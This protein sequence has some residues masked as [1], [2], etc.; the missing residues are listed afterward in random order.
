MELRNLGGTHRGRTAARAVPPS[1][2]AAGLL[3]LSACGESEPRWLDA[4]AGH[5]LHLPTRRPGDLPETQEGR[6]FRSSAR[7]PGPSERL[8]ESHGRRAVARSR[9]PSLRSHQLSVEEIGGEAQ[10]A[11]SDER[12]AERL[13]DVQRT[14]R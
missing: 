13:R 11:P 7:T 12:N 8:S 5:P 4:V 3:G 1:L 10:C 6:V 14:R 9:N 2:A